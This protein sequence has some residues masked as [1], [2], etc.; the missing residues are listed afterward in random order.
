[1]DL[2]E[3]KTF[4]NRRE[5]KITEVTEHQFQ[6]EVDLIFM[7][8]KDCFFRGMWVEPGSIIKQISV[9]EVQ[10]LYTS[11]IPDMIWTSVGPFLRRNEA[12]RIQVL[13]P[14]PSECWISLQETG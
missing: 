12:L 1:M 3:W 7:P 5:Y 9:R 11:I 13:L 10:W 6:G 8:K 2:G 4:H 14:A